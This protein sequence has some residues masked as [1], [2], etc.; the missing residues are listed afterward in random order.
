M[1]KLGEGS[2][3]CVF[4]GVFVISHNATNNKIINTNASQEVSKFMIDK[5][6]FENEIENTMIANK[7][8]Q[9]R[10]S[11]K[12]YGYSILD[13]T[14]I[15]KIIS[16]NNDV[17]KRLNSC[18]DTLQNISYI[19]N[20]YQIIYSKYGFRLKY[21]KSNI[22]GLNATRFIILCFNLYDGLYHYAK[23]KFLHYDIKENNI[24]YIPASKREKEKILFIDFG[25]SSYH[26]N[27][28]LSQFKYLI[29]N[30]RDYALPEPPELII[31]IIIKYLKET[32]TKEYCYDAFRT[33]YEY[34]INIIHNY[35]NNILIPL[36]YGNSIVEYEAD[37]QNLFNKMYNMQKQNLEKYIH[38][39]ILYYDIYKLAYT[40][41]GLFIQYHFTTTEKGLSEMFF[42]E[43]LLKSLFIIPEK[44]IKISALCNMYK[45]FIKK[46]I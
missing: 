3:G 26:K 11:M 19:D 7:L 10:S 25:L 13:K 43:I 17:F 44:R 14:D 23:A 32:T 27:I 12:I 21:L 15:Q 35:K 24:L 45:A 20:I 4:K 29:H 18:K 1:N 41:I 39:C 46:M 33:R 38:K 9:G 36:V 8:D 6:E 42:K 22:P 40:I 37:L 5:F 30:Y 16:Q 34:N 31:Y 2:Y 28:S